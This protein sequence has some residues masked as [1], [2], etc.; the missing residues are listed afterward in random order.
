[1]LD[2]E[3]LR[4]LPLDQGKFDDSTMLEPLFLDTKAVL[5]SEQLLPRYDNG[6]SAAPDTRL[7][8]T[9]DLRDLFSSAHLT[10]LY[11][12]ERE[13]SWLTSSIT[14]DRTPDL[15][16]YLMKELGVPEITPDDIIRRLNGAFLEAQPDDWVRRLYE[17]LN[18]QTVLRRLLSNIPIVRLEDGRHVTPKTNNELS[19]FLPTETATDFPIVRASVCASRTAR[20]FLES[21]GLKEPDPVDDVIAKRATK[22]S[23]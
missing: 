16:E 8:R 15:R 7:G 19:A 22:V 12:Q 17:F 1:M 6:Y 21:L 11:D 13:I 23:R 9:R 20:E 18:G 5:S 14:Q 3:V 2:T 10:A 4:C